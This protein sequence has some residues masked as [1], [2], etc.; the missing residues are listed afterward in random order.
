MTRFHSFIEFPS[1]SPESNVA[2][3]FNTDMCGY[4]SERG[5][6]VV[7]GRKLEFPI[8]KMFIGAFKTL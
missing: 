3:T 2:C 8:A 5:N 7:S 1:F 4:V 6:W